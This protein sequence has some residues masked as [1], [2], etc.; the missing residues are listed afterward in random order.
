MFKTAAHLLT[1]GLLTASANLAPAF[2]QESS[3]KLRSTIAKIE[4]VYPALARKNGIVGRV[5]LRVVVAPDGR[6]TSVEA[7]GGNPVFVE[8]AVDSVKKWKWVPASQETTE[9]VEVNFE[10]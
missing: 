1:V 3:V 7:V 4:P 5:K 9:V 10:K 8:S 2:A 6:A